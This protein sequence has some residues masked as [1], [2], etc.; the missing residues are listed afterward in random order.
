MAAEY[1]LNVLIYYHVSALV[2]IAV[3]D[4]DSAD[5]QVAGDYFLT[6]LGPRT[7]SDLAVFSIKVFDR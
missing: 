3:F 7:R 1:Y 4:S 6:V 5:V 2:R